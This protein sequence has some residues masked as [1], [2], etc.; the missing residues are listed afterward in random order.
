MKKNLDVLENSGINLSLN[1]FL[2]ISL[3][4]HWHFPCQVAG[5]R[6]SRNLVTSASIRFPYSHI[7][8]N[9]CMIAH[10]HWKYESV[11]MSN[12]CLT[13]LIYVS[14]TCI[15][16][17]SVANVHC[18]VPPLFWSNISR[19]LHRTTEF[20]WIRISFIPFPSSRDRIVSTVSFNELLFNPGINLEFVPLG[21]DYPAEGVSGDHKGSRV[22]ELP[23]VGQSSCPRSESGTNEKEDQIHIETLLSTITQKRSLRNAPSSI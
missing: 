16:E 15:W 3:L 12:I 22:L 8:W 20:Y 14:T 10:T 11:I 5:P 7:L 18:I 1:V 9:I 6:W 23:Q 2:T 19:N 17:I 13:C 4:I 21:A